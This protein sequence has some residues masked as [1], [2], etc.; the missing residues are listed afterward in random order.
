M[1]EGEE[2]V[3]AGTKTT[4]LPKKGDFLQKYATVLTNW[5]LDHG[6]IPFFWMTPCEDSKFFLTL[7][8]P[9]CREKVMNMEILQQTLRRASSAI[10]VWDFFNDAPGLWR[11]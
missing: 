2:H 6:N 7:H 8:N 11:G 1:K 5:Y 3:S 10:G 9:H 4:L